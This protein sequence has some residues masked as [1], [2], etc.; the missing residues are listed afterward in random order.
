MQLMHRHGKMSYVESPTYQ[1]VDLPYGNS[2]FTMTGRF[3]CNG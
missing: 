3:P 2:A 1:A